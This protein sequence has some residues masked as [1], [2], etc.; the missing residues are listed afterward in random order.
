MFVVNLVSAFL[1][2]VYLKGLIIVFTQAG[3]QVVE[4]TP[5]KVVFREQAV[6]EFYPDFLVED[7]LI[8]E[9]KAI[10]SLIL[11]HEAQLVNYLKRTGIKVGLL[12]NLGRSKLQWKRMV[13]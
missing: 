10:K 7:R 9:L 13:Y 11:E 6:D 8:V 4:Q 12:V 2:S 3:L 5:L 1:E